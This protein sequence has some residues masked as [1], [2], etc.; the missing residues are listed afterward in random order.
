MVDPKVMSM[1]KRTGRASPASLV[2]LT[3]INHKIR[4]AAGN[5]RLVGT[6]WQEVVFR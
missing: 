4:K 1:P 5:G 6:K 3:S 2:T